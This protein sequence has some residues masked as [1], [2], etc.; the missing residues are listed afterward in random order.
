[1]STYHPTSF[2][3]L[4]A[5][6]SGTNWGPAISE[7]CYNYWATKGTFRVVVEGNKKFL[8]HSSGKS[9]DRSEKRI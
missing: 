2:Q 3:E 6:S 7:A 9:C 4:A 1:M 8:H 5:L